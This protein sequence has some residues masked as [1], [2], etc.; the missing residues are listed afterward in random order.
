VGTA[1]FEPVLNAPTLREIEFASEV[2]GDAVHVTPMLH[3]RTFST[4]TGVNVYL[5]PENLQRAGSFKVRGAT[6][7]YPNS[8]KESVSMG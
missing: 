2:I 7:R 8:A 5:K 3:S 1:K 6:I 4:M